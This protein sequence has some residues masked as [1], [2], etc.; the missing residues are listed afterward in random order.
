[1]FSCFF[2]KD[3][4]K[5]ERGGPSS[6]AKR[7][8]VIL[9]VFIL[10]NWYGLGSQVSLRILMWQFRVPSQLIMPLATWPGGYP[11]DQTVLTGPQESGVQSVATFWRCRQDPCSSRGC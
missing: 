4:E 10:K 11:S 5:D 3:S 6:A 8:L 7:L 1:M 9:T 2:F